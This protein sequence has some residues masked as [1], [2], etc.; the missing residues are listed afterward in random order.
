MA[1]DCGCHEHKSACVECGTPPLVRDNFFTGQFLAARDFA[2]EQRYHTGKHRQHQKLLHGTGTVCGLKVV[3][4]PDPACRDR[5]VLIEKG[6]ALDCCGREIQ[7][8]ENVYVDLRAEIA[9]LADKPAAG[10]KTLQVSICYDECLTEFEPVLYSECACDGDRCEASRVREGYSVKVALTPQL[11][12]FGTFNY[13]SVSIARTGTI[14]V[15]NARRMTV[16]PKAGRVV[17]INPTQAAVFDAATGALQG[18]VP[19]GAGTA[20][21]VAMAPGGGTLYAVMHAGGDAGYRLR[22]FDVANLGSAKQ[23]AEAEAGA[24]SLDPEHPARVVAA[25]NRVFVLN[26]HEDKV[27]SFDA[28][29]LKQPLTFQPQKEMHSIAAAADGAQLFAIGASGLTATVTAAVSAAPQG[30]RRAVLP[31]DGN[32]PPAAGVPGLIDVTEPTRV[33]VSEDGSRL[34]VASADHSVHI[35]SLADKFEHQGSVQLTGEIIDMSASPRGNQL[36]ALQ[37]DVDHRGFVQ[38]VGA[39]QVALTPETAAGRPVPVG[40][41]PHQVY[42]DSLGGHLWTMGGQP[43]TTNNDIAIWTASEADCSEIVWK[44]LDGC[45]PC[46]EDASCVLLASIRDFQLGQSITNLRIDNRVREMVPSTT[47]LRELIECCCAHGDGKPGEPGPRGPAGPA[48]PAG[49]PGATGPQGLP[50]PAGAGTVGPQ[51]PAGA[52]GATGPQGPQ[53]PQ[54]LIGPPGAG[55]PGPQGPRG[56]QGPAGSSFGE[57]DLVRI[58]ALSWV[59]DNRF[60]ST[61]AALPVNLFATVRLLTGKELPAIVIGFGTDP[62]TLQ[63]NEKK[64]ITAEMITP[65]D[66]IAAQHIFRVEIE[67]KPPVNPFRDF[68]EL[69][70][71]VVPVDTIHVE[72]RPFFGSAPVITSATEAA[73]GKKAIGLAFVLEDIQQRAVLALMQH[74][75][76]SDSGQVR[77]TLLG[78]LLLDNTGKKAVDAEFLRFELP[79]GDRPNG[80]PVGIQGGTFH[81]WFWINQRFDHT[82]GLQ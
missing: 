55:A 61:A 11:P 50:G 75:Q 37:Q 33:T 73:A 24:G 74:G 39:N 15:A 78:D 60:P 70:G 47:T 7:V 16:D 53:G 80:S 48:G 1:S 38:F 23:I 44:A 17:I 2:D 13:A 3:E 20:V 58:N 34:F 42:Y 43:S 9:A 76:H 52:T 46:G 18:S 10:A 35:F 56:P 62:V 32:I 67:P 27:F 77:V 66:A 72:T 29:E 26:P 12:P 45:P 59:H 36:F 19:L 25:S 79:T 21:D 14:T 71:H 82:K 54:G 8:T 6:L 28:A 30:R 22:A 57:S 81:S 64:D 41:D 5:F 65:P 31:P 4:H 69:V 68:S 49:P 63:P 51:G 40:P